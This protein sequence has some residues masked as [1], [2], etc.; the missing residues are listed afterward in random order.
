MAKVEIY[1]TKLCPYCYRAKALLAEKGIAFHE[2][3]VS[4]DPKMRRQLLDRTGRRTVPQIFINEQSVGG[5]DDI[6]AL[7]EEGKLTQLCAAPP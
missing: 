7:D 1:T 5:Y 2:V 3:D 4:F 6:A